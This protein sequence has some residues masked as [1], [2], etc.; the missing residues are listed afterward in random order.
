MTLFLSFGLSVPLFAGDVR[1]NN[2]KIGNHALD[3]CREWGQNCGKPAADAYCRRRGHANARKFKVDQD[4]PPTRIINGGQICNAAGCD[5]IS[6]VVCRT[7][8][9]YNNPTVGGYALDLCREWGRNCGKPAADDYCQK[10]GHTGAIDY[11]V[12]SNNPPTRVIRG[13][14]I[15]NATSCDRIVFVACREKEASDSDFCGKCD[16]IG[17]SGYYSADDE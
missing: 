6:W 5:R 2:P 17:E 3:Y 10:R 12:R 1:I 16:D 7:G 13:D 14:A 15:C 11:L 9:V 4:K 8:D